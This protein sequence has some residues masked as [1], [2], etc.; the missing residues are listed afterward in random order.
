LAKLGR[1]TKDD[2]SIG[3]V[4]RDGRRQ[5]HWVRPKLVANIEFTERTNDGELRHASFK[6]LRDQVAPATI[7]R[8]VR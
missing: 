1:L 8:D 7:I 6:G 5:M 3:K 2:G 4:P